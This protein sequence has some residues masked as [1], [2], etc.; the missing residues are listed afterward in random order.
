MRLVNRK[1]SYIAMRWKITTIHNIIYSLQHCCDASFLQWTKCRTRSFDK[2][3]GVWMLYVSNFA[4]KII[5][6]IINAWRANIQNVHVHNNDKRKLHPSIHPFGSQKRVPF[7][8]IH[9]GCHKSFYV[10]FSHLKSKNTKNEA[11]KTKRR[12][13]E[14]RRKKT[15]FVGSFFCVPRQRINRII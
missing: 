9:S 6:I 10:L 11:A 4:K 3:P 12:R 15:E 8:H 14:K 13:G 5:I 2:V 1:I 7:R